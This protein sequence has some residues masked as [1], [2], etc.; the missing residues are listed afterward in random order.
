MRSCRRSAISSG[1]VLFQ[2]KKR[3]QRST[4]GSGDRPVGW[5]SS[6]PRGG[7][8]KVRALPR[9]FVFLGS[10]REES[11]MS[12]EFCRDV[13]D[14]WGVQRVCAK[15]VRAHFSFPIVRAENVP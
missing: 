10:R 4:F 1:A 2:A 5:G 14:P 13:P 6:T 7:G 11:G 8:Q 12:R 3:A 9:K 15:E